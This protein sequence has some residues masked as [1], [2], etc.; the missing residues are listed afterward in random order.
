MDERIQ[1]MILDHM[2]EHVVYYDAGMR[3][4]WA[5]SAACKSL[6][7]KLESLNGELC[8]QVWY[9]QDTPCKGCLVKKALASGT[10]EEGEIKTPDGKVWL[11]Q[12]T[13]V[14]MGGDVGGVVELALDMTALKEAEKKNSRAGALSDLINGMLD[15]LIV[16]NIRGVCVFANRAFETLFEL[17]PKEFMG[18]NFMQ[19]QGFNLQSQEEI[20]RYMPMFHEALMEG[21]SG[22]LELVIARREGEPVHVSGTADAIR[23]EQNKITH[24]VVVLHDIS[25][26]K[27]AESIIA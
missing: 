13:P 2:L 18:K 11:M 5:N 23:N 9:G 1:D 15:P 14:K 16:F 8:H 19:F 17:E 25:R 12:A 7:R 4:L 22:P 3:I 27:S 6:D 20:V 10:F 26:R 24:L 21:R